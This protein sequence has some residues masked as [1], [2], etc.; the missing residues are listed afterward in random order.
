MLVIFEYVIFEYGLMGPLTRNPPVAQTHFV[1]VVAEY[2]LVRP[3]RLGSLQLHRLL[4]L[5]TLSCF[6]CLLKMTVFT[7][8]KMD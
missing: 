5:L 8:F 3:L 6:H 4:F 7:E 2:G 1:L